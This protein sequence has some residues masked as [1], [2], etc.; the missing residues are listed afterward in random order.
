MMRSLP[1]AVVAIQHTTWRL[2]R[3]TSIIIIDW[4]MG[5]WG[6]IWGEDCL[7]GLIS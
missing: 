3:S 1:G 7:M 6:I 4:R 2:G 5:P